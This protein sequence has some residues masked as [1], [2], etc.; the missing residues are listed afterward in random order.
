MASGT[1]K[2]SYIQAVLLTPSAITAGNSVTF[3]DSNYKNKPIVGYQLYGVGS[4]SVAVT[5]L[6]CGN[7]GIIMVI[8]NNGSTDVTPTAIRVD[9]LEI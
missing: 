9:I 7:D 6:L 2:K 5:Q 3:T 1:I 4:A 8:K